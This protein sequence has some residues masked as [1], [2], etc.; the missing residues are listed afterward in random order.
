MAGLKGKK[1]TSRQHERLQARPGGYSETAE[2]NITT[3]HEEN[4]RQ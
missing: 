4:V 3:E 1:R 2:E